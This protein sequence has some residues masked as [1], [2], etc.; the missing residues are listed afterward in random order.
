MTSTAFAGWQVPM[1]ELTSM[2]W[3]DVKGAFRDIKVVGEPMTQILD[4][5]Y[6]GEA[7][8]GLLSL[9]C[10]RTFRRLA[11]NK[12][13]DFKV[14]ERDSSGGNGVARHVVVSH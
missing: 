10:W 13:E 6:R 11:S 1:A 3:L 7:D 8:V 14:I 5:V 4:L 2:K 12:E 9:L